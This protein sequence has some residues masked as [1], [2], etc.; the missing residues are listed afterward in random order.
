[1]IL[2]KEDG[3]FTVDNGEQCPV[4]LWSNDRNLIAAL[5]NKYTLHN[6][7]GSECF[8]KKQCF[9]YR[10]L[11]EALHL[12]GEE[13]E[14]RHILVDRHRIVESVNDIITVYFSLS[15]TKIYHFRLSELQVISPL[16]IGK[17]SLP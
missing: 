6:I 14:T 10:Q 9:L 3:V 11:R 7:G 4:K 13:R 16:L 12:D 15:C 1:M 5:F 2:H 17:K 8:E